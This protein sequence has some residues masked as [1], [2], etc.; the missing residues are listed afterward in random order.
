MEKADILEMTVTHLRVLNLRSRC[1]SASPPP[2]PPPSPLPHPHR[3]HQPLCN[4]Q[5]GLSLSLLSQIIID[6]E[7]GFTSCVAEVQRYMYLSS[8]NPR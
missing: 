5:N 6:Y 4:H 3:R 2:P 7:D 8:H 1:L